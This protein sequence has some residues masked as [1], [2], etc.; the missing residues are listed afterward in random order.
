M[1]SLLKFLSRES[2][3][4]SIAKER[5]TAVL[6]QDRVNCSP[7]LISSIKVEILR[8][9]S[10]YVDIDVDSEALTVKLSK[11]SENRKENN[12]LVANIPIKSMKRVQ[13]AP[14]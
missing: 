6:A 2:S 12:V 1:F 4:K 13:K 3:S 9:I 14:F 5:L 11:S 10:Q 7:E 8:A